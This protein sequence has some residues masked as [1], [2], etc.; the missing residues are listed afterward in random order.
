MPETRSSKFYTLGMPLLYFYPVEDF[1]KSGVVDT[2]ALARAY[3][4]ITDTN[5][6]VRNAKK[7]D[8]GLT[9]EEILEGAYLGN[10]T[11]MSIGGD[12][13]AQEHTVNK[14]GINVVDKRK[15]IQRSIELTFSFD[16]IHKENLKKFFGASEI[17]YP[18][19]EYITAKSTKES[20]GDY[21]ED[22]V[23]V[24]NDKITGYTDASTFESN[25]AELLTNKLDEQGKIIENLK[26]VFYFLVGNAL[27][28]SLDDA[29]KPYSNRIICAYFEYNSVTEKMEIKNWPAGMDGSD[30]SYADTNLSSKVKMLVVDE[31]YNG[32]I[33]A[34]KVIGDRTNAE[35]FTETASY[36]NPASQTK[37]I[38][39]YG[40][41]FRKGIK[42]TVSDGSTTEVYYDDT[43]DNGGGNFESPLKIES[44]TA[45]FLDSGSKIEYK[46]ANSP[47]NAK[48]TL[49]F[50]A[51]SDGTYS[52]TVE[53]YTDANYVPSGKVEVT[54]YLLG[55]SSYFWTKVN[56]TLMTMVVGE[57]KQIVEGCAM[58]VF[59]TKLGTSFYW[60]IPKAALRPNGTINFASDDWMTGGFVLAI[61]KLVGYTIPEIATSVD[62][63]AGGFISYFML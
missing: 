53:Y 24:I 60:V 51:V 6:K 4:G 58:L 26:G 14:D 38:E 19:Y 61:Q 11:D 33:P 62:I 34:N 57:G 29:L 2:M 55:W 27:K 17:S 3:S 35:K 23:A 54:G 37:Y 40:T 16:E 31:N 18:A 13:T 41:I 22:Y 48:L 42:V 50:K 20:G 5:G 56:S 43:S 8:T 46:T 47:Y 12:I 63:S 10:L 36:V 39:L 59:R 25:L 49:V 15:V 21:A 30:Y 7:E 32:G 45:T 1:D 28:D 9:P 44:G 52:V